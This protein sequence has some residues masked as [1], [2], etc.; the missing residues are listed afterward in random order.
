[1]YETTSALNGIA[2]RLRAYRWR[3]SNRTASIV[4][5]SCSVA[6]SG[7]RYWI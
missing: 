3:G 4:K 6:D 7:V 2:F 1:M 5:V